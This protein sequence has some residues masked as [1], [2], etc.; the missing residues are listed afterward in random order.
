[1]IDAAELQFDL[2]RAIGKDGTLRDLLADREKHSGVRDPRID[3][4]IIPDCLRY[5]WETFL[6][7]HARRVPIA[8]AVAPIT[9]EA[10]NA[11][12]RAVG[13]EWT[14]WEVDTLLALDA[15]IVAKLNARKAD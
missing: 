4:A 9:V 13:V 3:E 11:Y 6:I 14:P 8:G 1:L 15:R 10:F 5:L 2:G 12:A 7:L